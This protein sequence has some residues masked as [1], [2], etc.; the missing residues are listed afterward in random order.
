MEPSADLAPKQQ[1][2]NLNT[3][4]AVVP[5]GPNRMLNTNPQPN[6]PFSTPKQY[7]QT[8]KPKAG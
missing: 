6:H 2:A 8:A 7:S 4:H 5:S 1:P 3:A